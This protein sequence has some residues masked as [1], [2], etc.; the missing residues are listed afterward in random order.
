ML[1][2]LRNYRGIVG[3]DAVNMMDVAAAAIRAG[4][5]QPPPMS[6]QERLAKKFADVARMEMGQSENGGFIYRVNQAFETEVDGKQMV[7]WVNIDVAT[8]PQ[9]SK[10]ISRRRK[11]IEGSATQLTFDVMRWNEKHEDERRLVVDLNFNR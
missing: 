6:P 2:F 8:R 10:V 1:Q 4:Y 9:M 3:E 7:F 5:K 11:A